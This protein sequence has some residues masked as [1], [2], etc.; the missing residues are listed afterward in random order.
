VP[1]L[2]VVAATAAGLTFWFNRQPYTVP[3]NVTPGLLLLVGYT[4]IA[5]MF[6]YKILNLLGLFV[7]PLALPAVWASRG[8]RR[9][10]LPVLL[11]LCLVPVFHPFG[12]RVRVAD[13][14]FRLT[15]YGQYFTASGVVV[16]GVHGF[17][18]RPVVLPPVAVNGLAV[19]GAAGLALAVFLLAHAAGKARAA[20]RERRLPESTVAVA[21]ATTAVLQVGAA[22]PWF[23]QMNLFDRYLL[24][25]LPGLLILFAAQASRP[26]VRVPDAVRGVAA[27]LLVLVWVVGYGFTAEYMNYTRARADLYARLLRRGIAP[28]NIDGGFEYLAD[29]QVRRVGHI[30]NA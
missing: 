26:G 28:E 5:L 9:V 2:A 20:R 7:F 17:P 24:F 12:T 27:A 16:G 8:K 1:P 4:N 15:A 25:L 11:A 13:P 10:W 30:N 14:S 29:T 23:A 21:L 18:K 19:T 3:A 6:V 22:V